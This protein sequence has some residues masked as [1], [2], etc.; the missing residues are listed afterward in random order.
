MTVAVVSIKFHLW[1]QHNYCVTV[2]YND[3]LRLYISA[4]VWSSHA[5][6]VSRQ[7]TKSIAILIDLFHCSHRDLGR[8]RAKAG[9]PRACPGPPLAMPLY[10]HS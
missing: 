8:Y 2:R 3:K 4:S 9:Q 6:L 1:F 5:G 7:G 10:K